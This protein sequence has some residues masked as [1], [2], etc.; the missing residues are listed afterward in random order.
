MTALIDSG[1]LFALLNQKEQAHRSVTNAFAQTPEPWLLPTPAVTEIAYLFG[2]FLGP[3]AL[4]SFLEYLPTS[5]I[6][7]VEPNEE[8][9]Y[10]AA[11]LVRQYYD[12]P[13]DLVDS[14][15]V[16][17]AERLRITT[18]LT[19]DRRHFRL[20]RPRHCVAFDILP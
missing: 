14:L 10:R 20:V 5:N 13:L 8:D 9:Y 16:A 11:Q 17:I 18:I 7:L 3:I 12:A 19:T 1:F 4:A 15:L 2:K 6:H